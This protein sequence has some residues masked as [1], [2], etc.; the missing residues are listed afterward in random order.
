MK[1]LDISIITISTT[2]SGQKIDSQI[3]SLKRSCAFFIRK[4]LGI[5][6]TAQWEQI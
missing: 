2:D 4:R 3:V 1:N 5:P 6:V